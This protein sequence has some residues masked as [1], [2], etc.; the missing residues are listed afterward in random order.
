MTLV[1]SEDTI[2]VVKEYLDSV[3]RLPRPEKKKANIQILVSFIQEESAN[4]SP[5]DVSSYAFSLTGILLKDGTIEVDDRIAVM[6]GIAVPAPT[7]AQPAQVIPQ[8]SFH[9]GRNGMGFG[10][11]EGVQ[12]AVHPG[13][14]MGQEAN[15]NLLAFYAHSQQH[16]Y[17]QQICQQN[18]LYALA[19]TPRASCI[20]YGQ[21]QPQRQSSGIPV[22]VTLRDE[23][24]QNSSKSKEQ[25]IEIRDASL[26]L[27]KPSS[28]AVTSALYDG[29]HGCGSGQDLR[30]QFSVP[31]GPQP[32][33]VYFCKCAG[34]AKIKALKQ[35]PNEWRLFR[36]KDGEHSFSRVNT[37]SGI[38]SAVIKESLR[39]LIEEEP[40]LSPND[41]LNTLLNEDVRGVSPV[42]LQ[43]GPVSRRIPPEPSAKR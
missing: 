9:R 19:T 14:L 15:P 31:N 16:N 40:S 1:V 43:A 29:P 34:T 21:P 23:A 3:A 18:F 24:T 8:S 39:R 4:L 41:A 30:V 27:D 6:H 2:R 26:F 32:Y 35:G 33:V 12:P 13:W 38:L 7:V 28:Q 17:S 37:S 20:G 36:N 10:P 5:L 22:D 11:A 25:W 42:T